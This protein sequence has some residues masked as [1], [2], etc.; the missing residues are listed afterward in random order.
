M[1]Q[2]VMWWNC[3]KIWRNGVNEFRYVTGEGCNN[4]GF[5]LTMFLATGARRDAVDTNIL[6]ICY[7]FLVLGG[8]LE[9]RKE[10]KKTF[11]NL[12]FL[13]NNT[14]Q[15]E[16]VSAKYFWKIN[17]CLLLRNTSKRR[18]RNKIWLNYTNEIANFTMK[19]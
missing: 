4:I 12:C 11:V 7:F 15:I 8:S 1:W 2:N 16:F 9:S 3:S 13:T 6:I 18:I 10:K 14:I 19:L 5:I 17:F